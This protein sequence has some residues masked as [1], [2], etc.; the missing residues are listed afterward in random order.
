M[1]IN[2]LYSAR[3]KSIE[4]KKDFYHPFK[5]LIITPNKKN[6]EN[7]INKT[8]LFTQSSFLFFINLFLIIF[9]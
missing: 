7:I 5:I 3:L 6:I 9:R 1:C 8:N 4:L 2:E